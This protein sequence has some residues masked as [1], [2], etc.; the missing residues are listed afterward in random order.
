M[1]LKPF[2]FPLIYS[3]VIC[4]LV[5]GLYFTSNFI[6]DSATKSLDD[7]TYV[8][9]VVLGNVIPVMD[10]DTTIGNPYLD[11]NVKIAR[12]YY[13]LEDDVERQKES[14]IFYN[15]T[16]MPN[17]GID[18]VCD[19]EFEIV[20]IIDGTVIDIKEDELLGKIVEIRHEN[21]FVSSYAGLSTINVSKGE[22]VTKDTKIGM[23]GT[24]KVNEA[25]GNHLHFEIYQRGV[26]VDP[27][28]V[29]GKKI[30]D[31]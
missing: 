14:I 19:N 23:S 10:V 22:S 17:T 9:Q 11:E 1:K 28:K 31:L 20:S 2:V 21:E 3:L 30:G 27:L 29:L 6:K 24:N 12:Y 16:Y 8:S 15:D 18:Y 7:V 13:N 5:V 4:L 26:N 25:L